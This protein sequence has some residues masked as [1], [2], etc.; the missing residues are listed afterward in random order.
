MQDNRKRLVRATLVFWV[1]L[2]YIIAALVW[3]AFSL[4][5]QNQEMYRLK[6]EQLVRTTTD[7]TIYTNQLSEI[8]D[9]R[10]RNTIKYVSEGSIFLILIMFGAVFIY[11]SVRRQFQLQQ[12]QQNFVMAVT[13]ELKTPISVARLNL[14]TLQRYQLDAAKQQKLLRTSLQETL[15]L[16]SLINN[17]LISSQLD[18]NAY[19]TSKE[20]LDLSQL[21]ADEITAF[22]NRYPDRTIQSTIE[23][24]ITMQGDALLLKLMVS[25]LL[26]NANKYSEKK[27]RID[28]LLKK[29]SGKICLKII[30]E[31]PGIPDEEKKKVFRK[32]YRTGNEQTRKTKGTGL[33]LYICKKIAERYGATIT[34]TDNDPIGSTFTVQFPA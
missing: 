18:V 24:L 6:K 34:V 15:R 25:N 20:T 2:L 8:N 7:R 32:F 29:S 3:W 21:V 33:G 14:E 26:E 4:Q 12:Q 22:Q 30:D 5:H 13:H 1:L 11:R 10:R 27:G 16:D 19:P 31:G 23:E 17:I 9:E 28:C